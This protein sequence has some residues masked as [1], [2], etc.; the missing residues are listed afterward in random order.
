MALR[1]E[2]FGQ[3]P[4][5]ADLAQMSQR[6]LT[7]L[8]ELYGVGVRCRVSGGDARAVA[9]TGEYLNGLA[10]EPIVE[11]AAPDTPTDAADTRTRTHVESV[12]VSGVSGDVTCNGTGT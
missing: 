4:G 11:E 1:A 12:S 8:C 3:L 9:L 6:R 2:L 10:A 7:E 5:L